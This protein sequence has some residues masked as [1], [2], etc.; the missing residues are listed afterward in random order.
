MQTQQFCQEIVA[1]IA[2]EIQ[3]SV[4]SARK[5]ILET[6]DRAIKEM[7][8]KLFAEMYAICVP[9]K[10]RKETAKEVRALRDKEWK[11]SLK[12]AGGDT[13]KAC[14]IIFSES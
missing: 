1:P 9:T 5:E 2:Q 11:E 6:S 3:Q 12:K 4:A 13:N 7:E 10:K 8:L 14:D